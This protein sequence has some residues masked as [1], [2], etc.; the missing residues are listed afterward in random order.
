MG[1]QAINKLKGEHAEWKK[2]S[3]FASYSSDRGFVSKIINKKFNNKISY[4]LNKQKQANS[5]NS[6]FSKEVQIPKQV[7]T[8]LVIIEI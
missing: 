5:Q 1:K 7:L 8:L 4:L 3:V 6:Y 2:I